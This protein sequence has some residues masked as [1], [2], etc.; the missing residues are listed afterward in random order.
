MTFQAAFVLHRRPYRENSAIVDILTA[1]SGRLSV[2]ARLGSKKSDIKGLLQ[3]FSRLSVAFVGKGE[4]P[5]LS[6]VELDN[7]WQT[8]TWSGEAMYCGLYVNELLVRLLP[9]HVP[10]DDLFYTYEQTIKQLSQ[11]ENFEPALRHFE[12]S[13]L[14]ELGVFPDFS[15]IVD[16]PP[17]S[18]ISYQ[19]DYG[20]VISDEEYMEQNIYSQPA[21]YAIG[22]GNL[23]D[24]SVL[25]QY[26]KLMRNL[27]AIQLGNKPLNSREFFKRA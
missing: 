19:P 12:R 14:V 17:T 25:K 23:Q 7:E 27:L 13:L 1:E 26:K 22:Q 2:V 8:I 3:P 10:C 6:K 15:D 4:M 16:M 5:T 11:T 21:L 20:F 9:Q 24:K 18:N